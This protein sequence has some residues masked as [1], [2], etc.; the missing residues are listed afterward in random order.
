MRKFIS[1]YK[2]VNLSTQSKSTL[3]KLL[4]VFYFLDSVDASEILGYKQ[5][6]NNL[7]ENS[8]GEQLRIS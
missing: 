1:C 5:N 6:G 7:K 3:N 4:K 2:G 8:I